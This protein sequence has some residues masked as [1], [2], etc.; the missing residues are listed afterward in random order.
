MPS[1]VTDLPKFY[2]DTSF[3]TGDSPATLDFDADLGRA[4]TKGTIINDG[5]GDFTIAFSSDGTNFGNEITVKEG[6]PFQ[7]E[8]ISY[9]KLRIT[10]VADSSY[11]VI[12]I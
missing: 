12:V 3:V 8:N 4:A 5:L 1:E 2:E 10:W 7:F 6:D 11:R 9:R